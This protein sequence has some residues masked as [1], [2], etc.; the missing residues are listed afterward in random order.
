[1]ELGTMIICIGPCPI[2]FLARIPSLAATTICLMLLAKQIVKVRS[3][4]YRILR[5]SLVSALLLLSAVASIGVNH[6]LFSSIVN[7]IGGGGICTGFVHASPI[8]ICIPSLG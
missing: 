7:L 8:E 6:I 5:I 4:K 1:M 2:V 3:L